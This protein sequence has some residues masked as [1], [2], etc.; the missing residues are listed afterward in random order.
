M[1]VSFFPEHTL[2]TLLMAAKPQRPIPVPLHFIFTVS[3]LGLLNYVF[4]LWV[5]EKHREVGIAGGPTA[6]FRMPYKDG[7]PRSRTVESTVGL[8]NAPRR[9]RSQPSWEV[10]CY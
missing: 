8:Q 6:P 2:S 4:S 5:K 3:N 1:N 9:S 7:G 10:A